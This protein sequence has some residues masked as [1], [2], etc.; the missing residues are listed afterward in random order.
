MSS[1]NCKRP[2]GGQPL[3]GFT[4]APLMTALLCTV[5]FTA[6]GA[7]AAP[8]ATDSINVSY[9]A[10]A[11]TQPENAE[12]LYLHI[13]RAAKLVC[14]EPDI[15]EL[16]AYGVYQR[17]YARA[18]DDAVAKVDATALTALHRSKTQHSSPG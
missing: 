12:A 3:T 13:Q 5:A 18:V 15:R 9:V 1:M 10:A 4:A 14:H 17:C 7:V 6:T 2:A 8:Q 11:L 16:A